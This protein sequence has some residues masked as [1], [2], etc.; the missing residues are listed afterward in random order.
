MKAIIK[1][2][3]YTF[4]TCML[5]S[6]C[7]SI[8]YSKDAKRMSKRHNKVA[9]V[10]PLVTLLN[11]SGISKDKIL[12]LESDISF[13][14][15]NRTKELID[16]RERQGRYQVNL[17]DIEETIDLLEGTEFY[18]RELSTKELCSALEVDAIVYSNIDLPMNNNSESAFSRFLILNYGLFTP[19]TRVTMDMSITDCKTYETIY[20]YNNSKSDL[21]IRLGQD[22]TINRILTSATRKIPFPK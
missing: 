21:F 1:T 18:D 9:I 2:V 13:D 11:T 14:I 4:L 17:Q 15:Q 5:L 3:T 6:S 10:P 8:K 12:D 19:S 16:K 22:Y 7:A 20:H